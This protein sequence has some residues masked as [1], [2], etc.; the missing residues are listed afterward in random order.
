MPFF[1]LPPTIPQLSSG[2]RDTSPRVRERLRALCEELLRVFN[3]TVLLRPE[4]LGLFPEGLLSASPLE[5][6][7]HCGAAKFD[8]HQPGVVVFLDDCG[9]DD[10]ASTDPSTPL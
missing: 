5:Y 3:R 2:T 8:R 6:M 10:K 7:N 9:D 4:F 1:E